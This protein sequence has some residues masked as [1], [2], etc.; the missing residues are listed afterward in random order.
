MTK[1][2]EVAG[3]REELAAV[4]D[5]KWPKSAVKGGTCGW[6]DRDVPLEP[7]GESCDE[8][9][10]HKSGEEGTKSK[11]GEMQVGNGATDAPGLGAPISSPPPTKEG[12]A[13]AGEDVDGTTEDKEKLQGESAVRN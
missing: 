10:R 13:V 1:P 4:L 9:M 3:C 6:R 5:P 12:K 7:K 11:G 2:A 8:L